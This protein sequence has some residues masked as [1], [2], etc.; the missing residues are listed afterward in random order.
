MTRA[1]MGV[2]LATALT[3]ATTSTAHA[4]TE[5]QINRD[6]VA[7]AYSEH[8][9][10]ALAPVLLLAG[11]PGTDGSY[12]EPIAEELAGSRRVVLLHQRGTTKS[13]LKTIGAGTVSIS[14]FVEDIE[15]LRNHLGIDRWVILGHS[16]GGVLA[17]AYAH[18]HPDRVRGLVLVGSGGPS[19]A[20]LR[21]YGDNV[22]AR[23]SIYERRLASF[24]IEPVR[25]MADPHRA[26]LEYM[27]AT[28]PAMVFDPETVIPLLEDGFKEGAFNAALN[29]AMA[30]HLAAYDCREG[31]AALTAPALVV[32]GRQDPVGESTAYEIER[33]IPN[34][35]VYFLE[36]CGHWPFVEQREEFFRVV[37]EFLER[38]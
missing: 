23:L 6:G 13:P 37:H 35:S 36:R 22:Q 31:L 28:A 2:A 34:A 9:R 29:L 25:F 30:P 27:R 19:P 21:Y 11:G 1:S 26:L 5:G 10:G 38:V 15:A 17:M 7:L 14:V 8:G 3:V 24:W 18:E 20:W 16:W 33:A 32:Q 12:L 4:R